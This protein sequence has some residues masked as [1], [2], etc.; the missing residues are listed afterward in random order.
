MMIIKDSQIDLF[1]ENRKA[2][3]EKHYLDDL[4]FDELQRNSAYSKEL[5]HDDALEINWKPTLT[6]L[7]D[8]GLSMFFIVGSV[9]IFTLIIG[10]ILLMGV[11]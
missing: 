2:Y 8:I 11:K 3:Q 7:K 1:K 5:L 4:S 6:N 9:F 10:T